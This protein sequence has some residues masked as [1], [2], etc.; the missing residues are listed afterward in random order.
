[1]SSYS[2]L[3]YMDAYRERVKTVHRVLSLRFSSHFGHHTY[4]ITISHHRAQ[5]NLVKETNLR[6]IGEWGRSVSYPLLLVHP[7]CAEL[8]QPQ[9]SC[10]IEDIEYSFSSHYQVMPMR[11]ALC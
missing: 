11:P 2:T 4:I 7:P 5:C 3:M 1:M 8:S 9:T 6:M 10:R